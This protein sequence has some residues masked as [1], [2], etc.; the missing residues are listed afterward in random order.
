MITGRS[1]LRC[2]WFIESGLANLQDPCHCTA[3]A[4]QCVDP[5]SVSSQSS[6]RVRAVT[7]RRRGPRALLLCGTAFA[8]VGADRDPLADRRPLRLTAPHGRTKAVAPPRTFQDLILDAAAVLGRSSGCVI[9]QPYDM[10]MGAGTFH[11]ATFLR[12]VGPEPWSAAYVQ[13]SRRPDR[14]ALRRQPVPPAALLPVPGGASSPRR[15]TSSTSTSARSRALGI[16]HADARRALRRGQL[17][18]ADARRLGPRLG[19]LAATAWRSRSSPTSSRSAASTAGRSRARS[20]TDSSGWRCTL[21]GVESVFDLVW[22]DG[23]LGRVTYGDVY[24]QNEV[25]AVEVQ[26]RAG[27]HPREL[28]RALRRARRASPQ[29]CWRKASSRCPR[30][31]RC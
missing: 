1:P 13:P 10:E 30:T 31:S 28:F 8:A 12:A 16:D 15:R 24:H 9:L 4:A 22:T 23:P 20:P 3:Q 5:A 26:L 7:G 25:G 17:G 27:R 21:Q 2:R 11:T 18:V 14:R 6:S 19:G 29:C